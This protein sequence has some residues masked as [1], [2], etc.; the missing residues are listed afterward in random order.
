M[1][2]KTKLSL[3]KTLPVSSKSKVKKKTISLKSLT[4]SI[5]KLFPI[6]GIGSSAGGLDALERFF[7]HMPIDS[8][9]SFVII[10]HLEPTYKSQLSTLFQRFTSMKV[11]LSE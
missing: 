8:G 4:N 10:Q 5:P 6:V 2:K 11:F 9:M 3:G 7:I 1:A